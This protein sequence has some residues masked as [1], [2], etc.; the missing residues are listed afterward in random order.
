M[1]YPSALYCANLPYLQHRRDQQARK[2]FK[3]ILASDSCLHY[4]LPA[5]RDRNLIAILRAARTFPALA[6]RTKRYHAVFHKFCSI[7]LPVGRNLLIPV[8]T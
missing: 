1:P 5:P 2:I 6:S 8:D 4:L 3:S 7:T